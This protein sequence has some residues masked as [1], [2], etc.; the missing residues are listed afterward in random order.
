MPMPGGSYALA[1]ASPTT[2][3]IHVFWRMVP[4]GSGLFSPR[5]LELSRWFPRVN[6]G[7]GYTADL[8]NLSAYQNSPFLNG[9]IHNDF[10]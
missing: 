6:Y 5:L 1:N 7:R 9:K 2:P 4:P 8:L 10:P 3:K